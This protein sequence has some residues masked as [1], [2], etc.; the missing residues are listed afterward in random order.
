M[1]R[2]TVPG[3][4]PGAATLTLG[5]AASA[6]VGTVDLF[7]IS[8]TVAGLDTASDDS[9][10]N[11]AGNRIG[12]GDGVGGSP[13]ATLTYAAGTSLFAGTLVDNVGTTA[14]KKVSLT[15][16]GGNLTLQSANSYTGDTLVTGG[17]LALG[18]RNPTFGA[19]GTNYGSFAASPS[20]TVGSGAFLNVSGVTGG[21][22]HDPGTNRFAPAADQTLRGNGTV[23]GGVMVPAAA[24]LRGGDALSSP[25]G[26]LV[27]AGP[28]T[29]RAGAAGSGGGQLVVDLTGAIGT[30]GPVSKLAVT[31]AGN[32]VDVLTNSGT[33]KLVIAL[34]N[35]AGLPYGVP[36]SFPIATADS[37]FRR[38]G[39]G[40]SAYTYG[41]D[42]TLTSPRSASDPNFAFTNVSLMA[43]GSSP[44][45]LTL[46]FTPVPEPATVLAV[47]AIGLAAA[48]LR[49]RILTG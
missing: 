1:L 5:T 8:Q 35:D 44:T 21:F 16:T 47:A 23:Q 14:G 39:F 48:R 29:F 12:I 43:S 38:D 9:Q 45:T 4:L 27:V 24:T 34:R 6:A 22:N 3:A 25:T 41:Q 15:V 33:Q 11:P 19:P 13:T 31:G 18:F 26:T 30:G 28:V 40:V 32:T 20:V 7:G 36:V 2:A 10:V 37:G 46:S 17:T 49:R 42:F